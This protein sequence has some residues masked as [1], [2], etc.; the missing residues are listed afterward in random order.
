MR[1]PLL[2]VTASALG[3]GLAAGI[4]HRVRRLLAAPRDLRH[5]GLLMPVNVY[6]GHMLRLGR[7]F[8][9]RG[10]AM[11]DDPM[12]RQVDIAG[13]LDGFVHDPPWRDKPGGAVLWLHGGGLIAGKP[14]LEQI[15]AH[16]IANELGVLVLN[17]RYRLAPEHPFPAASD[18]VFAALRWMH[19]NADE[20][21]I[22]PAR[23]AVAGESAGAGLAAALAQRAHDEGVP[24]AFQALVYPM[25]DDRTAMHSDHEGRGSVIWTPPSNR[26]AWTAYLGRRPSAEPPPPYAAAGRRED[27]TGLAPAWIGVGDRD[28]FYAE[29]VAYAGRLADAGVPVEVLVEPGMYHGADELAA[30][31]PR[32]RA[33]RE[34]MRDALRRAIG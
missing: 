8:V 14:E 6:N 33:F 20:L 11:L 24:V 17:A 31:V 15:T 22:D 18:D 16:T 23:I 28:L 30:H 4:A 10:D 25:L 27:L 3:I 26:F 34:A 21:G 29:D 32:M 12:V 13:G 19:D 5:V 1:R 7:A 9:P 2:I